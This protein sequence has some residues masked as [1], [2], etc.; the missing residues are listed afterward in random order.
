MRDKYQF[1]KVGF[2]R[3]VQWTFSRNEF[4]ENSL[5]RESTGERETM[6]NPYEN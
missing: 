2:K 5:K 6:N 1:H 4:T 3:N